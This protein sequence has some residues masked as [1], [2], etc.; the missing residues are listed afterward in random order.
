MHI[1][2][3]ISNMGARRGCKII[4]LAAILLLATGKGALAQR[5]LSS[6]SF[7]AAGVPGASS[8]QTDLTDTAQAVEATKPSFTI[9]MYFRALAHKDTMKI[10]HMFAGSAI[11]PG[12]AQIYNRQAWKVPVIYGV[13]GGF[14]GGAIAFNVNYQCTG[15]TSSKNMRNLMI[16]GTVL[17]YYGSLL[18]GVISYKSDQK[19]LPARASLYSA[20]LPG[21]GQAYNGDYWKIPIFYGGLAVSG[22]CWAFNQKQ[23]KRY[24][25]MYIDAVAAGDQYDGAISL[26][27]MIW[28]RDKFRRYRDYSII[29]TVLV[30]VLNII[31]ANVFAYFNDFDIS[32][33]ITLNVEPGFIDNIV[34]ES[35]VSNKYYV[36]SV[37]LKINM[38]F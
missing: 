34:P 4:L 12:T 11:L 1:I 5:N 36:Q 10:A 27:N 22:Y 16:A 24:K 32:D 14:V 19:P 33:D 18:D 9:P 8:T 6:G 30:Y 29:A 20:L 26:D 25:N 2:K 23:Y 37:G 28:Y 38:N 13:A 15:K 17:T 31:D 3:I 7:T 35:T 21:L